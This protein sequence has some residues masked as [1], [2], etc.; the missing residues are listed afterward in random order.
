M[1]VHWCVAGPM[2]LEKESRAACNLAVS[3]K[4]AHS[5]QS[6]NT[7][8]SLTGPWQYITVSPTLNDALM[9]KDVVAGVCFAV[10][11]L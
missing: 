3:I 1:Y 10:A 6:E 11:H 9:D 8:M 7:R 4:Y 5:N 2:C